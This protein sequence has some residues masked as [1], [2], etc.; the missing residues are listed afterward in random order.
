MS[1]IFL[2]SLFFLKQ[3]TPI[4]K[5]FDKGEIGLLRNEIYSEIIADDASRK[6]YR[7]AGFVHID[8]QKNNFFI[9]MQ[10]GSS[11][12]KDSGCYSNLNIKYK[13]YEMYD[14]TNYLCYENFTTLD[15]G[16]RLGVIFK[17][18]ESNFS[19]YSL[20]SGGQGELWTS[21]RVWGKYQ[22]NY[23]YLNFIVGLSYSLYDNSF[24]SNPIL[25]KFEIGYKRLY[26]NNQFYQKQLTAYAN[27]YTIGF[28]LS[29]QVDF[30]KK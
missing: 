1:V 12:T 17:K 15:N 25:L 16:I 29:L 21:G 6:T 24:F 5:I 30:Q 2:F 4:D 3:F 28:G 27:D 26:F 11:S 13:F 19:I 7:R 10:R 20:V 23:N 18:Q 8:F 14:S 9:G 22:F